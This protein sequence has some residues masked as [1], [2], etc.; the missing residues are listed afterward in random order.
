MATNYVQDGL[1]IE[2]TA[3]AD[4]A[5]GAPVLVGKVVGVALGAVASGEK[6]QAA[7]TGVWRLPK[8]ASGAI[9]QGAQLYWDATNSVFTT[10]ASSNT[11]AGFAWEAAADGA[12]SVMVCIRL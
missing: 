5:S 6:G 12:T 1:T 2:F 11:Y 7:T 3:A 4:T 8:A 9:T 10:T